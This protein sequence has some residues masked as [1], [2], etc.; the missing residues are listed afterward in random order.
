MSTEDARPPTSINEY[1]IIEKMATGSFGIIFKVERIHDHRLFVM[2]RIPLLDLDA[3]QRKDAVREFFFM[4]ELYHPFIVQPVDAFLFNE[5]DL[6]LIMSFYEGGDMDG[7]IRMQRDGHKTYFP[8]PVVM[9]W[10]V[11]MLLAVQYLHAKGIAHRDLKTENMFLDIHQHVAVGDFGIAEK[12]DPVLFSSAA[13]PFHASQKRRSTRMGRPTTSPNKQGPREDEEEESGRRR[14]HPLPDHITRE[15]DDDDPLSHV[16]MPQAERNPHRDSLLSMASSSSSTHSATTGRRGPLAYPRTQRPSRWLEKFSHG[17]PPRYLAPSGVNAAAAALLKGTPLYMA[18]ETL[19]GGEKGHLGSMKNGNLAGG[20]AMEGEELDSSPLLRGKQGNRWGGDTLNVEEEGEGATVS[21]S[22]TIEEHPQPVSGQKADIWSLGCILYELLCL[23]HPFATKD[24]AMLVLRVTRGE[25]PPLPSFYPPEIVELVNRMLSMNPQDRPTCKELL[26]L[27]VVSA[28]AMHQ[29]AARR[30]ILKMDAKASDEL[31]QEAIALLEEDEEE[32]RQRRRRS[33]HTNG[34]MRKERPPS[35]NVALFKQLRRLKLEANEALFTE[36]REETERR[37]RNAGANLEKDHKLMEAFAQGVRSRHGGQPSLLGITDRRRSSSILGVGGRR[38]ASSGWTMAEKKEGHSREDGPPPDSPRRSSPP[39]QDEEDEG[40]RH[41]ASRRFSKGERERE[42]DQDAPRHS[43][44]L[45]KKTS[46]EEEEKKEE[47]EVEEGNERDMAPSTHSLFRSPSSPLQRSLSFK[48]RKP[49]EGRAE[50]FAMRV[51]SRRQLSSSRRGEEDHLD[52]RS[53]STHSGTSKSSSGPSSASDGAPRGP[54][55]YW[56]SQRPRSA[57]KGGGPWPAEGTPCGRRPPLATAS[58]GQDGGE[59]HR[60]SKRRPSAREVEDGISPMTVDTG[61]TVTHPTTPISH[62]VKH[63]DPLLVSAATFI[64]PELLHQWLIETLKTGKTRKDPK[65]NEEKEEGEEEGRGGIELPPREEDEQ[66]QRHL[67]L[68]QQ[69]AAD[70]EDV[71]LPQHALLS[72]LQ[73]ERHQQLR[74]TRMRMGS[75]RTSPSS[76]RS[77]S[78]GRGPN[79]TLLATTTSFSSVHNPSCTACVEKEPPEGRPA[80]IRPPSPLLALPLSPPPRHP[81]PFWSAPGLENV[82]DMQGMPLAGI[83]LEVELLRLALSSL[84]SHRAAL[85]ETA[86]RLERFPPSTAMFPG[87]MGRGLRSPAPLTYTRIF[88]LIEAPRLDRLGGE[89]PLGARQGAPSSSSGCSSSSSPRETKRR[90]RRLGGASGRRPLLWS[91]TGSQ[92]PPASSRKDRVE[93]ARRVGSGRG[94]GVIEKEVMALEQRSISSR[95]GRV[96][97]RSGF[98]SS[99]ASSS[100]LPH[101]PLPPRV[102]VHQQ[103][104]DPVREVLEAVDDVTCTLSNL[105]ELAASG[106]VEL[107]ARRMGAEEQKEAPKKEEAEEEE[108]EEE[109]EEAKDSSASPFSTQERKED[110]ERATKQEAATA[111][112]AA[113]GITADMHHVPVHDPRWWSYMQAQQRGSSRLGSSRGTSAKGAIEE[114]ERGAKDAALRAQRVNRFIPQEEKEVENEE[115]EEA[116]SIIGPPMRL[117]SY[118][119]RRELLYRLLFPFSTDA[120][121][122]FTLMRTKTRR[123]TNPRSTSSRSIF[124]A[125]SRHGNSSRLRS[126]PSRVPENEKEDPDD[127]VDDDSDIEEDLLR[128]EEELEMEEEEEEE[129]WRRSPSNL[130]RRTPRTPSQKSWRARHA[131]GWQNPR[132]MAHGPPPVPFTSFSPPPREAKPKRL[133]KFQPFRREVYERVYRYYES[134]DIL[135]RDPWKVREMVPEKRSWR[136]L[137][138]IDELVRLDRWLRHVQGM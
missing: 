32:R 128:Q 110:R 49:H 137:P 86:K 33:S 27:P 4:S 75:R 90:R 136:Y 135:R 108:E 5:N 83:A 13:P 34:I 125:S 12:E 68:Q 36:I 11:E 88:Q 7:A 37:M 132:S 107:E 95:E 47:R 15:E 50:G 98:G 48:K 102:Q 112:A 73:K 57:G 81:P 1:R 69:I 63:A 38:R 123:G 85:R 97:S 92:L 104:Q 21:A 131:Q 114:S 89:G 101:T 105:V 25:R 78:S 60:P 65:D 46:P 17:Y 53:P 116:D 64:H 99:L 6:C 120:P 94:G 23:R 122:H 103:F 115:N 10:L 71:Y 54:S 93:T 8:L 100:M 61:R 118:M 42:D 84:Y 16:T 52:G 130:S 14:K 30:G 39:R 45:S 74:Q 2:K 22:S 96:E 66:Y 109:E 111:V 35:I 82:M 31:S 106:A 67:L 91:R 40:D 43:R 77:P 41:D 44:R 72:R 134:H 28:F 129:A 29:L 18:P 3:S 117:W 127:H 80:A 113:A 20:M 58:T 70:T 9:G 76:R 56:S 121:C 79:S 51:G 119:A 19:Q 62:A 55:W 59:H 126:S 24:I 124:S 26:R 138:Y 87:M 133:V